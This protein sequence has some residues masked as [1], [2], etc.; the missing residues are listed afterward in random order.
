[1]KENHAAAYC[2]R[3]NYCIALLA[4]HL[5]IAS[6]WA[7]AHSQRINPWVIMLV[8]VTESVACVETVVC[9]G[10]STPPQASYISSQTHNPKPSSVLN[11]DKTHTHTHPHPGSL[12]S[13]VS[14]FIKAG[15]WNHNAESRRRSDDIFLSVVGALFKCLCVHVKG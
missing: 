2:T 7:P 5:L 9:T 1:M 13:H 6:L 3:V 10:F 14:L 8:R 11:I 12:P 4:A 15:K